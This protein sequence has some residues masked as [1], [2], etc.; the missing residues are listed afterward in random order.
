MTWI[1]KR[2]MLAAV[3]VSIACCVITCCQPHHPEHGLVSLSG[4]ARDAAA[5]TVVESLSLL[6]A[7]DAL[8]MAATLRPVTWRESACVSA[9]PVQRS[10]LCG[11]GMK[12]DDGG[13]TTALCSEN[14]TNRPAG[15]LVDCRSNN[16]SR[17]VATG[18]VPP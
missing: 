10:I 16:R 17:P 4:V 11:N 2:S 18:A 12:S 9:R 13:V 8:A 15:L 3:L 5:V 14:A 1:C 6:A 7:K